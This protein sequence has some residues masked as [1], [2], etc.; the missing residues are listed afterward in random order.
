MTI[1]FLL[2]GAIFFSAAAQQISGQI[3]DA[4]NG[5]PL[6]GVTVRVK[7]TVV[8]TISDAQGQF[9][10]HATPGDTLLFTFL[11]YS[12]RQVVVGQ[13]SNLAIRLTKSYSQLDQVVVVGY[14]QMK[15]SDLSSSQ[16]TVSSDEIDRTINTTFDQALQ[17]RAAGVYVSSPSG[18]P[19]AAPSVI[20]RG[21]ATLTQN[22]QPLYVIDGVQIRPGNPAD[23]PYNHPTGFSNLLSTINPDDIASINIL[24]GPSATAIYGAAGVT[25]W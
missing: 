19:G 13:Q 25:A 3:R 17:G 14:G 21:L 12:P 10:I 5:E 23:D 22:A 11:G 15:K 6:A 8:G 16:V 18:Q 24:E 7:G 20:I 1:G 4:E 9:V 2:L